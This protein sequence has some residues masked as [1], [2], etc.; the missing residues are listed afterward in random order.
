MSTEIH[1]LE[2]ICQ[3]LGLDTSDQND[4]FSLVQ[5]AIEKLENNP[6]H[7]DTSDSLAFPKDSRQEELSPEF[8]SELNKYN[9]LLRQEFSR[10]REILLSRL[11][12]T[13]ESFK[14][15][16][17][18]KDNQNVNQLIHQMYKKAQEQGLRMKPDIQICHLLALRD[19]EQHC[20]LNNIVSS[21]NYNLTTNDDIKHAIIPHV[22]D[23]GGRTTD[24]RAP[25]KETLSFQ[26]KSR[27]N[28]SDR[29]SR[30]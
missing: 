22:P 2:E 13:I 11:N 12:C 5:K 9:D 15:K 27:F 7:V 20:M 8:W 26:Q 1:K 21:N 25:Q 14:W 18:N 19:N 4:K 28:K 24:I 23:R 3:I 10:K 16:V 6:H 29:R 17:G 30:N